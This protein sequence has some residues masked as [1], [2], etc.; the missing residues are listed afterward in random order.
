ML[1]SDVG[2]VS[3]VRKW[4]QRVYEKISLTL[5]YRRGLSLPGGEAEEKQNTEACSQPA[6]YCARILFWF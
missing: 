3:S 6:L 2:I 1:W 4:D 5:T